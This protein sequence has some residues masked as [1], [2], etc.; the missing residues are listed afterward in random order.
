MVALVSG[1]LDSCV[2][3]AELSRTHD[4]VVPVY[5]R[6]GSRWE[7]TEQRFADEFLRRADL[8]GVR[9]LRT[10]GFPMADVYPEHWSISGNGIPA[11]DTEAGAVYIPGRNVVLIS[12]AAVLC[13]M[14]G[15]GRLALGPL[16]GNPFPDAR[17]EFFEAMG[18]ALSMGLGHRLEIISPFRHL[19][20]TQVVRLGAGLPLEWTCSC[21]APHYGLHCGDCNKCVERRGAFVEAGIP[22]PTAY[23]RSEGI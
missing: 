4:F 7:S 5:V 11:G 17:A 9:S 6:V 22:D 14:E 19:T 15:I 12:K 21:M 16:A 2:L 3:A 8:R 18:R 1:G 10:F 13:A 23:A 20:K